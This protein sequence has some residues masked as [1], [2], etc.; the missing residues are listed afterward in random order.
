MGTDCKTA[1]RTVPDTLFRDFKERLFRSPTT[2]N[3]SQLF[4]RK[5]AGALM[6]VLGLRRQLGGQTHRKMLSAVSSPA[7]ET[8]TCC[9]RGV[10]S[11]FVH[12]IQYYI[13][14]YVYEYILWRNIVTP[15]ENVQNSATPVPGRKHSTTRGKYRPGAVATNGK[16]DGDS[17]KLVSSV[18]H[19]GYR[20][21]IIRVSS[22]YR[23]LINTRLACR[24]PLKPAIVAPPPRHMA[25]KGCRGLLHLLYVQQPWQ[26]LS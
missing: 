10:W 26:A 8:T 21:G 13:Y 9:C 25:K 14:I 17:L 15:A 2:C 18:Y 11:R 16:G 23:L 5:S 12:R 3:C 24:P 6:F 20:Q 22:G 7:L 4:R 19:Q 1:S